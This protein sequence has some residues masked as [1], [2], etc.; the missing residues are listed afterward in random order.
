MKKFLASL[1]LSISTLVLMPIAASAATANPAQTNVSGSVTSSGHPVS[2]ANVHVQCGSE[3]ADDNTANDG[4]YVVNLLASGCPA[5]AEITVTATSGSGAGTS[6]GR[7][8]RITTRL[9]VA[10]INVAL[11]ELGFVT[12][13]G[14]LAAAGGAFFVIRRRQVGQN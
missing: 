2:N 13:A 6:T 3:A 10:V 7:A 9:N 4:G 11:P 5:G 14:A 1:L 12:G 8:S